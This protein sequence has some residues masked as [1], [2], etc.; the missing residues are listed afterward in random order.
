[1]RVRIPVSTMPSETVTIENLELY[2]ETELAILVGPPS[3][4][5]GSTSKDQ[6]L[7]PRTFLIHSDLNFVGDIGSIEIPRWVAEQK[8]LIDLEDSDF[9]TDD[10]VYG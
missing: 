7:V 3:L 2:A 8:E 6:N 5:R 4:K 1:M 9:D 10:N